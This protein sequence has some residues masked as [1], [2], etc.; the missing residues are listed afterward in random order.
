MPPAEPSAQEAKAT[1]PE[2]LVVEAATAAAD[3][4]DDKPAQSEL[5]AQEANAAPPVNSSTEEKQTPP[6]EKSAPDANATS[7]ETPTVEAAKAADT[8]EEK[9]SQPDDMKSELP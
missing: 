7:P 4:V 6:A 1:A 8:V 3:K 5:S 9:P 2:K